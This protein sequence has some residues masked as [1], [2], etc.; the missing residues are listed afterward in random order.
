MSKHKEEKTNAMRILEQLGIAYISKSYE[1]GDFVDGLET[2]RKLGLPYE[3]VYKTLVAQGATRAY[4][5]FVLPIDKELDLKKAARAVGEK[6]VELLPVKEITKVT[7]YIRGGC[8]AIG[9]KKQYKTILSETA[10][11]MPK[12][13]VSAGKLGTQFELAPDDFC[14]ATNATYADIMLK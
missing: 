14:R 9:M 8:T 11:T 13:H 2:A 5:V 10:R 6:S 3:V 7:G 12:I 4:Y 1:A